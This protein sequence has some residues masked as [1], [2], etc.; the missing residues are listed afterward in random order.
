MAVFRDEP[1]ADKV[2]A[3]LADGG[4]V[5]HVANMSE[6]CSAVPRKS[7]GRVTSDEAMMWLERNGIDCVDWRDRPFGLLTADVRVAV[8]A[9]SLGDGIA[10]ALATMLGVPLLTTERA[11]LRAGNF[12]TIDLIR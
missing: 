7:G 8:P 11:F 5:M 1:G 12:A 6:F 4:C 9:L 2:A 3:S 10:V